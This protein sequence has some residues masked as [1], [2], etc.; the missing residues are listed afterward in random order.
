[1]LLGF[2]SGYAAI[3]WV[4]LAWMLPSVAVQNTNAEPPMVTSL[5]S[6]PIRPGVVAGVGMIGPYFRGQIRTGRRDVFPAK[7]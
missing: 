3:F 4:Y 5:S 6:V 2:L 7:S 1:M